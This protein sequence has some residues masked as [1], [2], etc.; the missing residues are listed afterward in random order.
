MVQ[1]PNVPSTPFIYFLWLR[2]LARLDGQSPFGALRQQFAADS[3][4]VDLVARLMHSAW[5]Q[6]QQIF[7][8]S[9]SLPQRQQ[10]FSCSCQKLKIWWI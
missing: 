4:L 10:S 6:G 3:T 7:K 2:F 1:H 8:S 9:P 5:K